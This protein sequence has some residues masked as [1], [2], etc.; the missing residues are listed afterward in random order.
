MKATTF[1][2]RTESAF[3]H[4]NC[5]EGQ[6][7]SAIFYHPECSLPM[8]VLPRL[9]TSS[10]VLTLL[11]NKYAS[12][13]IGP[14]FTVISLF[15]AQFILY[16]AYSILIWPHYISQIRHLPRKFATASSNSGRGQVKEG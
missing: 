10:I 12:T 5:G 4:R 13:P 15:I 14:Y 16:Q 7:K 6:A 8:A 2:Y 3:F 11:A 9:I 1:S